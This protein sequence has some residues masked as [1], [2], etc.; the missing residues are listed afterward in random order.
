M[1][2]EARGAVV[3][4]VVA[5]V[6]RGARA[7]VVTGPNPAFSGQ[8]SY[9]SDSNLPPQDLRDTFNQCISNDP[10]GVNCGSA[11]TGVSVSN[12]DDRTIAPM[13]TWDVSG[14]E[15]LKYLFASPSASGKSYTANTISFNADISSWNTNSVANMWGTFWGAENFNQNLANWNTQAVTD[16]DDMFHDAKDFNYDIS[17][18]NTA[19]VV[20]FSRMFNDA[21]SFNADIT[22]WSRA[23]ATSN[24]NTFQG[25]TAW[26]SKYRRRGGESGSANDGPPNAWE[27]IPRAF[28]D[29]TELKKYVN[30]CLEANPTGACDCSSATVNCGPAASA[31]IGDWNITG[32][33]DLYGMFQN[34]WQ[35]NQNINNWNTVAVTR[36]N[37]LFQNATAFNQ[38]LNQWNVENVRDMYAMFWDAASFNQPLNSWNT[39]SVTATSYMF[40]RALAFNQPMNGWNT[41]AISDMGY[42]FGNAAAFNHPVNGWNTNSVTSMFGM[43]SSASA[44]NQPLEAWNTNSVTTMSYM[45]ANA[46]VFDRPLNGWNTAAVSHMNYM[47]YNAA[48]FNHPVNGWNTNSVASMSYMFYNAGV[49]D[50]PLNGWNTAAVLDMNYMFAYTTFNQD[51]SSWNVG[52]VTDMNY[53]FYFSTD[54]LQDGIRFWN[55]PAAAN[56]VGMFY[57][58]TAWLT[59]YR[60]VDGAASPANGPPSNWYPPRPFLNRADLK[61]A[62]DSCL[63][64]SPSGACDCDST[65]VDCG[66]ALYVALTDWNTSLVTDMSDLFQDKADF[67]GDISGWNT[68]A[69]TD[70]SAM[71]D[72]ARSFSID[73]ST[74]DTASV[75]NMAYMFRRASAFNRQLNGWNTAAV[76]NMS[77]MFENADSTVF[78]GTWN[79]A[80]VQDMSFMFKGTSDAFTGEIT[81]TN[82]VR[83]H[84]GNWDTSSVNDM[85]SMFYGAAAFNLADISSWNTASVTDMGTMFRSASGFNQDISGWDVS[86]V[87]NM[88]DMFHNALAYNS[89]LFGGWDTRSVTSMARMFARTAYSDA[90]AS[91]T[92]TWNTAS[93]KDFTSMFEGSGGFTAAISQWDTSSATTMEAMFKNA[94]SFTSD[95]AWDTSSVTSMAYMFHGASGFRGSVHSWNV[96]NV[97][98]MSGM[99][100]WTIGFSDDLSA[101]N[102][103]G[104]LDM[105]RMFEGAESFSSSLDFLNTD[106]VKDMS[107]LFHQASTFNGDIGQWNTASVTDMSSM[108]ELASAFNKDVNGWNTAAVRDMSRM[109]AN[110]SAF[111][112]AVGNWDV[113]AVTDMQSMFADAKVFNQDL[114]NWNTASVANMQSMF[115]RAG[116]FDNNGVVVLPW[117]TASVTDMS[118]MFHGTSSLRALNALEWETSLV[119]TMDSMFREA[120]SF[121]ADVSTW[122]TQ[123]V[124]SMAYMFQAAREFTSAG[125]STI[126]WT[127]NNVVDMRFMFADATL[128][129]GDITSWNT[130]AVTAMDSMFSSAI[131]FKSDITVW[132][133]ATTSATNMFENATVWNRMYYNPDNR[134]TI[135]GPPNQF[136]QQCSNAV[137]QYASVDDLCVILGDCPFPKRCPEGNLG[138][139]VGATGELCRACEEGYYKSG[140]LCLECPEHTAASAGIAAIFVVIAGLAGFK[141][142]EALGAVST[143]MIKKVVETL[144]FFNISFSVEIGWP[145]PVLNFADWLKAFNFSIEFLAPEC[146]GANIKWPELFWSS[147]LIIPLTVAFL[148][149]LRDKYAA[150][151]YNKI[152]DSIRGEK[153]G[154]TSSFWI[155]RYNFLCGEYKSHVSE[156]GDKVVKELQRQYK[157]RATLRTF[158][159]LC[160][161][162][163]YLPVCR[164]CLQAFDCLEYG[165]EGKFA[166]VHDVDVDCDSTSHQITMAAACLVLAFIGIG[167]PFFVIQKV[168]RIRLDGKLDDARTLDSWGAL[169]DIYRRVEL[170]EVDRLEIAELS[171][172]LS[173]INSRQPSL[174]R[175]KTLETVNAQKSL[176]KSASLRSAPSL[177]RKPT[178]KIDEETEAVVRDVDERLN[179]E[180]SAVVEDEDETK[181]KKFL[182]SLKSNVFRT[183]SMKARARG[184]SMRWVDRL[185][186]YYLALEMVVKLGVILAGSAQIAGDISVY[187]LVTVHWF[188]ALFVF[189]CQP[190]RIITLGFGQRKVNNALNKT[191]SSAGFLQGAIPLIGLLLATDSSLTG[192]STGFLL[193]LIVCLLC[194]RVFFIVSERFAVKTE[195]W[196]FEKE[197]EET[198]MKVNRK[199]IELGVAGKIVG[200]YALKAQVAVQRRKVRARLEA[201]REAMLSK[202]ETMRTAEHADESQI[203]ALLGIANEM[204]VIV[205]ACTVQPYP[206]GLDPQRQIDSAMDLLE[207]LLADADGELARRQGEPTANALYLLLRVHAYDRAIKQLDDD[208]LVYAQSEC[209]N[210]LVTLGQQ[211]SLLRDEQATLREPFGTE[212]LNRVTLQLHADVFTDTLAPRAE[213]DDLEGVLAVLDTVHQIAV[214]HETWRDECVELLEHPEDHELIGGDIEITRIVV[215]GAVDDLKNHDVH[216]SQLME[217][218]AMDWQQYFKKFGEKRYARTL[219]E[220]TD[221][222][223][224]AINAGDTSALETELSTRVEEF[225]AWCVS[226]SEGIAHCGF[227]KR[228]LGIGRVAH[229]SLR[230]FVDKKSNKLQPLALKRARNLTKKPGFFKSLF[231]GGGQSASEEESNDVD[232][233]T[234]IDEFADERSQSDDDAPAPAPAPEP[235]PEPPSPDVPVADVDLDL[236]ASTDA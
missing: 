164:V 39:N 135:D 213:S 130:D 173:K 56:V 231:G 62:V 66:R 92:Q 191:E 5:V 13:N 136:V 139:S 106:G 4:V 149:F 235:E 228:N 177:E 36:M 195:K 98:N 14:V 44:F 9:A 137:G 154:D 216:I 27:W 230:A 38:P 204:A 157:S 12:Q 59:K 97:R 61:A 28:D 210:E 54:F 82:G 233:A 50:Q 77:G 37:W 74:I 171:R 111:G 142:A 15:S 148:F 100:A 203:T 30:L 89:P 227:G 145:L 34:K 212:E 129:D 133:A 172:N 65:I 167:L 156:T 119:Q 86:S 168:R 19:Q 175:A 113:S 40:Y 21:T 122:D 169:Y 91:T 202:I 176:A 110:A 178:F 207:K 102:T 47:F 72:G 16:M 93:V 88:A 147:T 109:F 196:N 57:G 166:L 26:H 18:W 165:S 79:T 60:L 68:A 223:V 197:P 194:V 120:S 152:V 209:V 146:A 225:V 95:L 1:R 182:F 170:T 126:P 94:S 192:L 232:S 90:T 85:N 121:N 150:R 124:T 29:L 78:P 185:A 117:N 43:F 179:E 105:A 123:A 55:V 188:S 107:K 189:I 101:W 236:D 114:S 206:E 20:Y 49:F 224:K 190:W 118:Y 116:A 214:K 222:A 8:S 132:T 3:A 48:A 23:S 211:V 201:T 208:M 32:L 67:N 41:A 112:K 127:T 161:T 181:N 17:G 64:A 53:M 22:G 63:A 10:T 163:L 141:A 221:V 187:G 143:N 125:Q 217:Y 80:S 83:K 183:A 104:L 71:F 70:M 153:V 226:A 2:H 75:T 219:R 96:Y 180:M 45:F 81:D 115:G 138:C 69:V 215:D 151:R 229:D 186:L 84:I 184:E 193:T 99:F 25:A 140:T 162:I 174:K 199:F 46:G 108:F 218:C 76:R 144:Q 7:I 134:G 58:A 51:I 159:V 24:G 200:I 205:N 234:E 160:M 87:R 220:M 42:M 128:F 155:A 73:I 33:T 103:M 11:P 52:S 158:G 131:S 198:A 6:A 31:S 35:F